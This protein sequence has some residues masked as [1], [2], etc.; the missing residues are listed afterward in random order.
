MITNTPSPFGVDVES[1][2]MLAYLLKLSPEVARV[3]TVLRKRL[4]DESRI[5]A[6]EKALDHMLLTLAAGAFVLSDG[7]LVSAGA[8]AGVVL[9][10][11][12][13][14]FVGCWASKV[15][16]SSALNMRQ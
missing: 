5:K 14:G 9:G 7:A 10:G 11:G 6:S 1:S 16:E 13:A 4:M 3:R 15:V 12:A 8:V 2:N